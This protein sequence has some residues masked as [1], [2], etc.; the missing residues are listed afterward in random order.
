MKKYNS[1]EVYG[2]INSD[3]KW[4]EERTIFLTIH[5]SIAYGLNNEFS[6]IDY[7]GIGTLPSARVKSLPRSAAAGRGCKRRVLLFLFIMIIL[8]LN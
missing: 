8:F 1:S 5:G 4:L 7:R 2:N 6:D 3:L